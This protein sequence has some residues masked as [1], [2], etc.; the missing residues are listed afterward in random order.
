MLSPLLHSF[1]YHWSERFISKLFSEHGWHA[2]KPC[3]SHGFV[4]LFCDFALQ[5]VVLANRSFSTQLSRD[6][7]IPTRPCIDKRTLK[8]LAITRLSWQ[9]EI[10]VRSF[11]TTTDL[12]ARSSPMSH[13]CS[14]KAHRR[15]ITQLHLFYWRV[16]FSTYRSRLARSTS[17]PRSLL[18]FSSPALLVGILPRIWWDLNWHPFVSQS[19]PLA[20]DNRQ[21]LSLTGERLNQSIS[22]GCYCR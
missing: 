20:L 16:L 18:S 13:L 17:S 8:P 10:N 2:K 4:L 9:F 5:L 19:C 3:D 11:P 22:V 1:S 7:V 6:R 15:S 14:E 21:Y 12:F